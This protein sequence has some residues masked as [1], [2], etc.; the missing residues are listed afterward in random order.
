M[1][2]KTN[3]EETGVY[4]KR[5][6]PILNNLNQVMFCEIK[7]LSIKTLIEYKERVLE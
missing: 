4:Q 1:K 2:A 7:I 3:K 5:Y 6:T